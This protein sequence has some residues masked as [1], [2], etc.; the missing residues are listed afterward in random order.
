[1]PMYQGQPTALAAPIIPVAT[2]SAVRAGD[3]VKYTNPSNV[4]NAPRDRRKRFDATDILPKIARVSVVAAGVQASTSRY[5]CAARHQQ[6]AGE[7]LHDLVVL[8]E[9]G[10]LHPHH[11]AIVARF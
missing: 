7:D 2:V 8:I 11:A 9:G 6:V 1:M 3:D 4:Q 10:V 5:W